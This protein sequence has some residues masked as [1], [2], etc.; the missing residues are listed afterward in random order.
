MTKFNYL[1]F[2][3][4]VIVQLFIFLIASKITSYFMYNTRMEAGSHLLLAPFIFFKEVYSNSQLVESSFSIPLL[5]LNLVI[6][7]LIA[8]VFTKLTDKK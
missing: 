5:I 3:A 7:I 1:K 8:I 2:I 6:I 4:T